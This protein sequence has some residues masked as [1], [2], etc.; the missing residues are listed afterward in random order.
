[1]SENTCHFAVSAALLTPTQQVALHFFQRAA[2]GKRRQLPVR[3]RSCCR[4]TVTKPPTVSRTVPK[5]PDPDRK[6]GR[7]L[8]P[9]QHEQPAGSPQWLHPDRCRGVRLRHVV[10]NRP[11]RGKA[12]GP[13]QGESAESKT[14]V[15]RLVPGSTVTLWSVLWPPSLKSCCC[16]DGET[17]AIITMVTVYLLLTL[18]GFA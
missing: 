8:P 4:F 1:M 3:H 16:H 17:P 6:R 10:H 9:F 18:N 2:S 14:A 11:G 13:H 7:R 12:E 5:G 15:K